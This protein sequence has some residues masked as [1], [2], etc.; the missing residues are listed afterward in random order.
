MVRRLE[1][2]LMVCL[3]LEMMVAVHIYSCV[4][5][6]KYLV[7][8]FSGWFRMRIAGGL[9]D[10]RSELFHDLHFKRSNY[11]SLDKHS[12]QNKHKTK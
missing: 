4:D 8:E 10:E 12:I 1:T 6:P 5:D 3:G 11:Y 9:L 7:I 2:A